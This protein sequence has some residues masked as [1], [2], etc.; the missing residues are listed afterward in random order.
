L[1]SGL[2]VVRQELYHL[3]HV[4]IP[5]LLLVIFQVGS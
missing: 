5:F 3:S 4:F 2:M 1:N